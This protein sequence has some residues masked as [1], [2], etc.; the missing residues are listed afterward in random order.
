MK[1]KMHVSRVS[2]FS[3]AKFSFD[4]RNLHS[5][6]WD[7]CERFSATDKLEVNINHVTIFSFIRW[8]LQH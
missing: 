7:L 6:E 2:R 8:L 4:T 3:Q 1:L 5:L